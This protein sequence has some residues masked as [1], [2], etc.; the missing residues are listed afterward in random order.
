MEEAADHVRTLDRVIHEQQVPGIGHDVDSCASYPG[1]EDPR[2]HGWDNGVLATGDDER[3]CGD[4]VQPRKSRPAR[5][6][7]VG[8][9]GGP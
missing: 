3:W 5:G 1:S 7:R 9:R 8:R 2:V 4:A 6:R